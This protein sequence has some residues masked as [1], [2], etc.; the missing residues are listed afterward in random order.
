MSPRWILTSIALVLPLLASCQ[1]P[2]AG[3]T[4]EIL[5]GDDR[6]M[7]VTEPPS[8]AP[9]ERVLSWATAP[10]TG[11]PWLRYDGTAV[12]RI[13]HE[14]GR[15]PNGVQVWISFTQDGL[16]PGMAAG[17]LAQIRRISDTDIEIWNNTSGSYFARV[18]VF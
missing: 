15:A 6:T 9:G 7:P 5:L 3:N 4:T 14:L 12:L 11:H 13:E 17:D 16:N 1:K 10:W 2:A 8:P 18:V